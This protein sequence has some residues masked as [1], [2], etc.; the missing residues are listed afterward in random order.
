[1][2]RLLDLAKQVTAAERQD[3]SAQIDGHMVRR[4]IWQT[5]TVIIYEDGEGH[6][7]RHLRS[8]KQSW[9]VILSRSEKE[10]A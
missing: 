6:F 5:D 2:G 9:P 1:M 10:S 7:W 8:Y 3:S 4:I